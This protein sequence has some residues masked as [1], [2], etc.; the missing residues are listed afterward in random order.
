MILVYRSCGSAVMS[1]FDHIL[2]CERNV[3]RPVSNFPAS[4]R[5]GDRY[6]SILIRISADCQRTTNFSEFLM[7][8]IYR[9][10]NYIFI[11]GSIRFRTPPSAYPLGPALAS[12]VSYNLKVATAA[13]QG[14][15][16]GRGRNNDSSPLE[17]SYFISSRLGFTSENNII[18]SLIPG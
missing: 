11:L 3:T 7:Q 6:I 12:Y 15:I 13:F 5:R 1:H 10:L 16:Q 18:T 8:K 14:P 2:I 4:C 17:R 9:K